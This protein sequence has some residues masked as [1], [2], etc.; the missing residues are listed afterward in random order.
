MNKKTEK[1]EKTFWSVNIEIIIREI[2][3]E[4]GVPRESFYALGLIE[5]TRNFGCNANYRASIRYGILKV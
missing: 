2:L 3:N 1:V 4:I 5:I